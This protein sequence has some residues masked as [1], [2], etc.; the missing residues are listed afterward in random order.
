MKKSTV[1]CLLFCAPIC[2]NNVFAQ[3]T[4]AILNHIAIFVVDIKKSG[5]FY[6]NVIGLDTIPEPF[7]DGKHI[8]YR[9]GPV[10]H[11]HLIEGAREPKNYFKNNHIC[12]SVPSVEEFIVKLQKLN[13]AYENV[14]G[15]TGKFTRRVDGVTQFWMRDPDGYW[16]EIND[17]KD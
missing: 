15:E 8:W 1:I 16:I 10:S 7:H 17:A 6:S 4:K 2:S 12:F 9:V 5:D 3:K 13:I 11:L 14:A